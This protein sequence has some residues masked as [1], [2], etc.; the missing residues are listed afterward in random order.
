[1]T[2]L[3]LRN[4]DITHGGVPPPVFQRVHLYI[5]QTMTSFHITVI[6]EHDCNSIADDYIIEA[7][8]RADAELRLLEAYGDFD[9]IQVSDVVD[10]DEL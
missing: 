6:D 8:D 5:E 9:Y 4:S 2:K 1:M 10:I 7:V 3:S